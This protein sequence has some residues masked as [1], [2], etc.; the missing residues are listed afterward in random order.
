MPKISQLG[1]RGA[2]DDVSQQK[3]IGQKLAKFR[4]SFSLH[5]SIGLLCSSFSTSSSEGNEAQ[6]VSQGDLASFRLRILAI[7]L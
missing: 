3:L 6:A 1:H 4:S 2:N 7:S 5:I